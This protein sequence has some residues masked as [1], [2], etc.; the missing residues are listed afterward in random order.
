MPFW[1]II[2]YL[3]L[4]LWKP[5]S[6]VTNQRLFPLNFL[7]I[8]SGLLTMS[9]TIMVEFGLVRTHPFGLLIFCIN[10]L[11]LFIVN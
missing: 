8:G 9:I 4:A 3:L 2:I 5:V 1:M 7:L 11:S 6:N 10:L